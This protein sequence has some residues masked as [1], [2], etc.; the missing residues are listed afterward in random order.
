MPRSRYYIA[1]ICFLL[2]LAVESCGWRGA[3]RNRTERTGIVAVIGNS[4]FESI[5]LMQEDGTMLRLRSTQE[6][7]KQLLALQGK[8][9][10]VVCSE[11]RE[12]EKMET[13]EVFEF[14]IVGDHQQ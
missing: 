1:G 2:L 7:Q 11:P 14:S 13:S 12:E 8:K 9:V 6:L 3:E 5:A 10:S 4:P